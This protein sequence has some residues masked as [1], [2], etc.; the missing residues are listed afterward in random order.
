MIHVWNHRGDHVPRTT[1]G[2]NSSM[3]GEIECHPKQTVFQIGL[4]GNQGLPLPTNPLSRLVPT[5]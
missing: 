5:T 4:R 3:A 1:G 2:G